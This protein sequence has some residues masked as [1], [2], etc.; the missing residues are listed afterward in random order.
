VRK[1]VSSVCIRKWRQFATDGL[2]DDV[3]IQ[4]EMLA[5]LDVLLQD[6]QQHLEQ[7]SASM[8]EASQQAQQLQQQHHQLK[9]QQQQA[10]GQE[11]ALKALQQAALGLDDQQQ[12]RWLQTQ[13]LAGNRRLA[14]VLQVESGFESLVEAVLGDAIKAVMVDD[15]S[16]INMAYSPSVILLEKDDSSAIAT[17]ALVGKLLSQVGREWVVGV[18][19]CPT[20]ARC[21]SA[22]SCLNGR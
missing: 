13:G 21:L 20:L 10:Q 4:Q 9:S 5:E 8:A 12:Q 16:A 2:L 7:L 11:S 22:T 3:A 18:K 15:L 1:S 14:E 6:E 19:H 17:D